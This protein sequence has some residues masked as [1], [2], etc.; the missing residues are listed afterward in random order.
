MAWNCLIYQ[1][2]FRIWSL[3]STNRSGVGFNIS[4]N[5]LFGMA[6]L[7]SSFVIFLVQEKA[8]KAKHLQFVSGVD[9]FC[10]W[11]ASFAWDLIN[12]LV[13]VVLIII[14]FAAFNVPAYAGKCWLLT[15]NISLLKPVMLGLPFVAAFA[16]NF[17]CFE[18]EN[19]F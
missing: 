3:S 12:Y 7:A 10:Y 5:I 18:A 4:F 9:P 6:F 16:D 13:P 14:I 11:T 15:I 19:A 1:V 2:K 17:H 8:S